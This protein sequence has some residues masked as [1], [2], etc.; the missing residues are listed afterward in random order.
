MAKLSIKE[1]KAILTEITDQTDE[2]LGELRQ[3]ERK[4]VQTA[5]KSWE[6]QFAKKEA[7]RHQFVA[8]QSF[9]RDCFEKGFQYIAGVDEVGRGPLAGPVVACAVILPKD[10]ED[11][12]FDDSKKLSAAKRQEIFALIKEKALAIGV[13]VMDNQVIDKVNIYQA[14][15]LAM[16][17]AIEELKVKPDYLLLDA[18]QLDLD[19]PQEA[20]I[21]G[22]A[23]SISIAAASIVAKEIRDQMMVDY[24][25]EFPGYDF[26]SNAGYGT[27]NHLAGLDL[28]G[29][30]PIH[31]KSFAP[32]A[33]FF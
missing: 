13:G 19:M 32:V 26:S 14:T 27:K 18:M 21:K 15:K 3:D 4:G 5:I 23:K 6:R 29:P 25:R 33:K 11:L 17:Q 12:G 8:M 7:R 10:I 30:C 31:R 20:I 22:D 28:Q 24:D 9:E 2:R 1:V 16:I